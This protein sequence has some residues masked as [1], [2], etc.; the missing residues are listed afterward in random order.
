MRDGHCNRK[1]I[2]AEELEGYK[3]KLKKYSGAKMRE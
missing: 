2:E 3:D 1:G